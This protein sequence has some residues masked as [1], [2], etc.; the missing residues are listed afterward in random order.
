MANAP[1]PASA[2]GM[3]LDTLSLQSA[4]H[5]TGRVGEVL[6]ASER[7]ILGAMHG[8]R[9]LFTSAKGTARL[10]QVSTPWPQAPPPHAFVPASAQIPARLLAA[11]VDTPVD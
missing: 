6:Q 8:D 7:L 11:V 10:W 3:R 9:A 2:C 4:M 5:D 1:A